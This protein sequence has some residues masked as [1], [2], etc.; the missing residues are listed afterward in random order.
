[1]L[2]FLG[3]SKDTKNIVEII[4]KDLGYH[5]NLVDKT[6][7]CFEREDSKR[8]FCGKMLSKSIRYHMEFLTEDSTDVA[9]LGVL[10][11]TCQELE[12]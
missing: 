11:G 10:L 8:F 1:M 2:M 6:V 9:S 3:K 4:A 12:R 7:A 5:R